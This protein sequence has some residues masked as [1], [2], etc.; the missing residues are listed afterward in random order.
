M[1]VMVASLKSSISAERVFIS[2]LRFQ[3]PIFQPAIF[4][5]ADM[6]N[7]DPFVFEKQSGLI[8]KLKIINKTFIFYQP[9][10][11]QPQTPFS[12]LEVELILKQIAGIG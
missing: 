1:M 9:I 5:A 3:F 11:Q 2:T 8:N 6:A 7:F 4:R 12:Y 10:P